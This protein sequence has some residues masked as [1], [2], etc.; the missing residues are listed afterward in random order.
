MK[1]SDPKLL[2]VVSFLAIDFFFTS[3]D[4][5]VHICFLIQFVSRHLVISR[6]SNLFTCNRLQYSLFFSYFC[7]IGCYVSFF[8]SYFVSL[9]SL[10]FLGEPG[11]RFVDFVYA[12]KEAAL[13]LIFSILI[14]ILFISSAS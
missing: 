1:P 8:I 10:S 12:F 7:D 9:D 11:Q 5:S 4:N 14:I 13:D 2:F 3:S 6:L